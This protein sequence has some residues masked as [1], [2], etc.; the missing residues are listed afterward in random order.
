MAKYLST[1]TYG[2]DRGLVMLFS[3]SGV[4]HTVIVQLL[5]GYTQLVSN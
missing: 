2:T 1:K 3:D 4:V 5:H